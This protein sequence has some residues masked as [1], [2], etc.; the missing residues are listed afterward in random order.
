MKTV[1]SMHM[2]HAILNIKDKP[3]FFKFTDLDKEVIH[4]RY[5]NNTHFKQKVK[6]GDEVFLFSITIP[7]GFSR[8]RTQNYTIVIKEADYARRFYFWVVN[9]NKNAH[10]SWDWDKKLLDISIY[11]W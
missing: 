8:K 2:S 11:M 7:R 10:M 4:Y 9:R 3:N 1:L 5:V 6:V